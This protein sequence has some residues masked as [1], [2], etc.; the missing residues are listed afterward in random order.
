MEYQWRSLRG[1]E[2]A[3]AANR[4]EAD[5]NAHMAMASKGLSRAKLYYRTAPDQPWQESDADPLE[6]RRFDSDFPR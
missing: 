5:R 2:L 3:T 4:P 6:A 1:E